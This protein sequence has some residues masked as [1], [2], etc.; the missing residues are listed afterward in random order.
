MNL[1]KKFCVK[2]S[3][4]LYKKMI[5]FENITGESEEIKEIICEN[6]QAEIEVKKVER[7]LEFTQENI[8]SK[9]EQIYNLKLFIE[10]LAKNFRAEKEEEEEKNSSLSHQNIGST[11][12]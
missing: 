12:V 5:Y 8:I 2:M 6:Q 7:D 4:F 10:E 3:N 11:N 1:V 9:E